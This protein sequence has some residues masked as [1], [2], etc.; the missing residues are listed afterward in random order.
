ME[1]EAFAEALDRLRQQV[2]EADTA[3]NNLLGNIS[4]DQRRE[5]V[6]GKLSKEPSLRAAID[7]A[8]AGWAEGKTL[9]MV[10]DDRDTGLL[11]WDRFVFA[12][13]FGSWL[14]EAGFRNELKKQQDVLKWL[15]IDCWRHVG[16]LR[17]KM[18]LENM[19]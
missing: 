8:V 16:I 19:P 1:C 18:T 2:D 14:F 11:I 3:V 5:Q 10:W 15:L 12:G 4:A 6:R 17:W 7:K 13:N 9:P